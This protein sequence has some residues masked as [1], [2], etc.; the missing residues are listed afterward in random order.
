[1]SN[2]RNKVINLIQ[3]FNYCTMNDS[4][5]NGYESLVTLSQP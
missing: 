3:K 2:A 1:M 5:P 4:W